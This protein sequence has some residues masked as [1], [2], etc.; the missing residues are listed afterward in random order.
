VVTLANTITGNM[1]TPFDVVVDSA[2][3]A[4]YVSDTSGVSAK[5]DI[6]VFSTAS[7]SYIGS[8][9]IS[10]QPEGLALGP[11]GLLYVASRSNDQ[12]QVFCNPITGVC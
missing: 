11:D 10:G 7:Q 1:N 3:S 6:A 4:L 2:N 8:F 5:P 9:A 12:V